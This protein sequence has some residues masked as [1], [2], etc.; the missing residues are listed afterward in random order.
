MYASSASSSDAV[1][2]SVGKHAKQEMQDYY[3]NVVRLAEQA[4]KTKSEVWCDDSH[5]S[6]EYVPGPPAVYI[7]SFLSTEPSSLLSSQAQAGMRDALEAKLTGQLARAKA[8]EGYAKL[9]LK[10]YRP[11]AARKDDEKVFNGLL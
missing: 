11:I 4:A 6:A 7:W 10:K 1:R 9:S 8:R 3:D 2:S 5:M